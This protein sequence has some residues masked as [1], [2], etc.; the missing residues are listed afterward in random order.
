MKKL[1]TVLAIVS[2]LAVG[3]WSILNWKAYHN[4]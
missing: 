3:L 1:L 4:A 2:L